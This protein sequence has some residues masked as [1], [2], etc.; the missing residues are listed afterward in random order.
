MSHSF[1]LI[2]KLD[3][4]ML[5]Y[6]NTENSIIQYMFVKYYFRFVV[7]ILSEDLVTHIN[8]T[9]NFHTFLFFFKFK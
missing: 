7:L 6:L 3:I 4:T 2:M 8:P 5:V 9:Y 1:G